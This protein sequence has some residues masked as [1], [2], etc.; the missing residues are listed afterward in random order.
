MLGALCFGVKDAS[1][2][3]SGFILDAHPD[4]FF[5][6]AG[7]DCLCVC[8]LRSDSSCWGLVVT[9]SLF[10]MFHEHTGDRCCHF[11]VGHEMN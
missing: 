11:P 7:L 9:I 1:S 6:K 3:K 10:A 5:S 8:A 4:A 2:C